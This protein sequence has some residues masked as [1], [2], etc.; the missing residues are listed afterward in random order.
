MLRKKF[1]PVHAMRFLLLPARTS[2]FSAD[3]AV[4]ISVIAEIP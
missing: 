4:V 1:I 2:V 3:P